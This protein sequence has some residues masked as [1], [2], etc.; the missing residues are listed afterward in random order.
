VYKRYAPALRR[1][2]E[3]ARSPRVISDNDPQPRV[4]FDRTAQSVA[5]N[6]S[7][8]SAQVVLSALSG[9]TVTVNYS[10]ANG[11]AIAG[12][13]Y[14]TTAGALT[15][16]PGD[17]TKLVRVRIWDDSIDEYDETFSIR[18]SGAVNATLT[19]GTQV[20]TVVDN[21]PLPTA[22]FQ[23]TSGKVPENIGWARIPV[24]LSPLSGRTAKVD[25]RTTDGTARAGKDYVGSSGT[26]TFISGQ[27]TATIS[28]RILTDQEKENDE[29]FRVILYS[30]VNAS[31]NASIYTVAIEGD[32][33]WGARRWLLYQ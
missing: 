7:S 19:T 1:S 26:L 20:V 16:S 23:Q 9:R 13:D 15:F 6:G 5:E 14:Y 24:Q 10:T 4:G 25:Y 27:T 21:D 18:L 11:T 29:T 30:P 2:T 3:T 28:V 22:G 8:I 32:K 31:L 12:S 17:R 33:P